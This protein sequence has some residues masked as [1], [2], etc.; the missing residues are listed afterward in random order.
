MLRESQGIRGYISVMAAL[1][2]I[3]SLIKGIKCFVKIN[4]GI[5][6][7]GDVFILYDR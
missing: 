2:F 4:R 7:I 6:L 3:Y 5:S 1:K